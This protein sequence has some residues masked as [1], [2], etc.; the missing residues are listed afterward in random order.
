MEAFRQDRQHIAESNSDGE[1]PL[2]AESA[3]P[4]FMIQTAKRGEVI[5]LSGLRRRLEGLISSFRERPGMPAAAIYAPLGPRSWAHRAPLLI[6][7]VFIPG[8]T[9]IR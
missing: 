6:P 8:F 2:L 7:A 3:I 9:G 5:G 4:L 1:Y